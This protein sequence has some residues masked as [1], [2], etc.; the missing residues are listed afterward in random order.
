M[1]RYF[2]GKKEDDENYVQPEPVAN[3]DASNKSNKIRT[4]LLNSEEEIL[5]KLKQ[6]LAANNAVSASQIQMRNRMK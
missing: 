6:T 1:K 5:R 3:E 4:N 2:G